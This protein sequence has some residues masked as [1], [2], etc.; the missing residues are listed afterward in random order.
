MD[1]A[2]HFDK[3]ELS[4]IAETVRGNTASFG[5]IVNKYKDYIYDLCYR[6]TGSRQ[7]AEDLTQE[8]FL[9]ALRNLSY[10]NMRFKF[11]NW[12][13]TIA[14]NIIRNHLRRKK[15]LSFVPLGRTFISKD[16]DEIYIEPEDKE[17]GK[18]VE[19]P[20]EMIGK[21][22]E[23]LVMALSPALRPAFV[24]RHMHDMK[25]EEIASILGLPVNTVKVHLNRA[26]TYLYQKYHIEYD[27][28]FPG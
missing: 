2:I 24:L 21:W 18:Q 15:I 5:Y 20:R 14:L 25:Y 23:K 9:R 8:A 3:E 19:W 4:S 27:E 6:M 26:R 16:G 10:Y 28:T 17:A 7:E 12:L 11:S 22:T 13:Y 1:Q